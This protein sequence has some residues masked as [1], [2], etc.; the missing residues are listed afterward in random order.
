MARPWGPEESESD[1]EIRDWRQC[2]ANMPRGQTP[3]PRQRSDRTGQACQPDLPIRGEAGQERCGES[4]TQRPVSGVAS[5][6]DSET[7]GEINSPS[8]APVAVG[9]TPEIPSR[10]LPVRGAVREPPNRGGSLGGRRQAAS[11]V[12]PNR[13]VSTETETGRQGNM[14]LP[15]GNAEPQRSEMYELT[16]ADF[17]DRDRTQNRPADERPA[18]RQRRTAAVGDGPTGAG[19]APRLIPHRQRRAACPAQSVATGDTDPP[20]ILGRVLSDRGNR[21]VGQ[22]GVGEWSETASASPKAAKAVR[23][24]RTVRSETVSVNPQRSETE[25]DRLAVGTAGA[26]WSETVSVNR[27]T[28]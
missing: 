18:E 13:S 5:R 11:T 27:E 6:S 14:P 23:R 20:E 3:N 17:R 9:P 4:E 22:S 21:A 8:R 2:W 25:T 1:R 7:R 26:I 28:G 10:A 16:A 19:K 24:L 12:L 15:G